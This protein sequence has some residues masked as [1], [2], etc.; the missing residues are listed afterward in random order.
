[1]LH[2]GLPGERKP[3]LGLV[4]SWEA[5]PEAVTAVMTIHHGMGAPYVMQSGW[6]VPGVSCT[7]RRLSTAG[8]N[9]NSSFM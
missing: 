2:T 9:E 6:E 3:V 5:G 1:M 8:W 4:T 7:S